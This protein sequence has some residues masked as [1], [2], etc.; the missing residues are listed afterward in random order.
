M[1]TKVISGTFTYV[2]GVLDFVTTNSNVSFEESR[3]ALIKLR[4]ELNRMLDNQENCPVHNNENYHYSADKKIRDEYDEGL[5]KG[6][7][8]F[9]EGLEPM[10]DDCSAFYIGYSTA[11]QDEQRKINLLS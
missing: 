3:E 11:Y 10:K 9:E 4:D 2:D 6:K 5:A 7:K 1:S 8:D